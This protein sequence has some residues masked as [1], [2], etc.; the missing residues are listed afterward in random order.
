M[1]FTDSLTYRKAAVGNA[2]PAGLV[3]LMYDTL[4]GDIQRSIDAMRNGDIERRCREL[5]HAFQ[6]LQH[7]CTYLDVK[8]GGETAECLLQFYGH[9]R[10]QLVQAQFINSAEILEKQIA[11][12]LEVRAAWQ[13]LEMSAEHMQENSHL[14]AEEP[15]VA[16]N[17]MTSSWSA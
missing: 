9:I 1:N 11:L 13:A 4:V 3:I 16:A 17:V 12:V 7:L 6:V 14:I 15:T 8:K 2:S 10:E 5:R